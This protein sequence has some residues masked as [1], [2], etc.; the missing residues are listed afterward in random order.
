MGS[1]QPAWVCVVAPPLS[2]P[3]LSGGGCRPPEAWFPVC[4]LGPG[5][6]PAGGWADRRRSESLPPAPRAPGKGPPALLLGGWSLRLGR[7]WGPRAGRLPPDGNT[8]SQPVPQYPGWREALTSSPRPVL[9]GRWLLFQARPGFDP[10]PPWAGACKEGRSLS[11]RLQGHG[12]QVVV[13]AWVPSHRCHG[14]PRSALG[15][16]AEVAASDSRAVFLSA[17]PAPRPSVSLGRLC[18]RLFPSL[19]LLGCVDLRVVSAPTSDTRCVGFL[20]PGLPHE[21]ASSS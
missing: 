7:V 17:Q 11:S 9:C 20:T 4:R 10:L 3:C 12:A 1:G 21:P 18:V 15:R 13:R 14:I 2:Q 16:A 19:S 6:G 8:R 5:P